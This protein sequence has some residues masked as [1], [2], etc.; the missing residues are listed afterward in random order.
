LYSVRVL[1]LLFRL[2]ESTA[3]YRAELALCKL[4]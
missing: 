3:I 2:G 1:L 4:L